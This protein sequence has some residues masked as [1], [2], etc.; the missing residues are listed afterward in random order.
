MT[1]TL[2][3]PRSAIRRLL[4]MHECIDAVER[5]FRSQAAG[6]VL[7]P[8]ITGSAVQYGGFHV[9]TCGLLDPPVYAAKIN[10]N[11]PGNRGR[12][13]L[14][15]VQ[16]VVALFD[17]ERGS[18]LALLD[19]G[20]I[21]RL[22]T[23]AASAVAARHLAREDARTLTICGCG[24]QGRAH[25]EALAL[26]RRIDTVFAYDVDR[27]AAQRF[28][29]EMSAQLG[30]DV[31]ESETLSRATRTSDMVAMCTTSREILLRCDDVEEGAFIAAVGADSEDKR[32]LDPRLVARSRVIVDDLQQ[33]TAIGELHHALNAGLVTASHV[34]GDLAALVAGRIAGRRNEREITIFDS[35]GT[36]LED[37]AAAALVF[38]RAAVAGDTVSIELS[39]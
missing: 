10:A 3:I 31:R 4:G 16:G 20:E 30:L 7:P 39:G 22:R 33:C 34:A 13:G 26:V 8:R 15:T 36:A 25:L 11:F 37:V 9:K 17:A 21:T 29:S 6:E 5:A 2:L 12:C 35:T 32:E 27:D 24:V 19:S 1:S 23:A 28:A 38:A 14:P 18:L